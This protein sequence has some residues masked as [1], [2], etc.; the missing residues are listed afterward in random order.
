MMWILRTAIA[1]PWHSYFEKAHKREAKRLYRKAD[2]HWAMYQRH[3]W[4]LGRQP[5][6]RDGGNHQRP[7]ESHDERPRRKTKQRDK[8]KPVNGY[9]HHAR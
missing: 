3:A 7:A 1:W 5:G 9:A 8:R 2:F 4:A 6:A